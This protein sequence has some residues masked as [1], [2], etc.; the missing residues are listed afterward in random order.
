MKFTINLQRRD[1]SVE[2]PNVLMVLSYPMDYDMS[3]TYSV[4]KLA[5]YQFVSDATSASASP[6]AIQSF[7]QSTGH[8]KA[9]GRISFT[10]ETEMMWC[11]QVISHPSGNQLTVQ[12]QLGQAGHVQL[13]LTDM[14]G[15]AVAL[16]VDGGHEAGVYDRTFATGML[17][18]GM[19]LCHLK[20]D[21]HPVAKKIVAF[22]SKLV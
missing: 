2:A 13:I 15:K 19:Y 14:M 4:S 5:H 22:K 9:T 16:L 20:F 17:K 10:K 7:Y 3:R 6:L 1:A 8:Q 18:A 21:Q 11:L 12:Y